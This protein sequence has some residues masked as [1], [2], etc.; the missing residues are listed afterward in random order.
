[1]IG[2]LQVLLNDSSDRRHTGIITFDRT[3]GGVFVPPSGSSFP[4]SPVPGELFWNV[5]SGGLYR[6]DNDNVE[7][8]PVVGGG[9]I[10]ASFGISMASS[11]ISFART[12]GFD[13]EY[14]NGNCGGNTSINWTLGQKQIMTL[15][16][17]VTASFVSGT[18]PPSVGN[19]LIRIVQGSSGGP[20]GILWPSSSICKWS[21]AAQPSLT[22]GSGK[23]DICSFYYN[24]NQYFGVASLN[25]A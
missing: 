10:T 9:P 8:Q 7:W 15:T 14:N 21:G 17:S 20:Y 25:F 11:S 13:R 16:A 6:R 23:T 5:L 22:S 2:F 12:I 4:S 18:N 24:G 3:N 1:M 19:Y